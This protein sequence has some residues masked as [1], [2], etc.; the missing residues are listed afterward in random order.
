MIPPDDAGCP[1]AAAA[2]APVYIDTLLDA[3]AYDPPRIFAGGPFSGR[4][5]GDASFENWMSLGRMQE[6]AWRTR[7]EGSQGLAEREFNGAVVGL[8]QLYRDGLAVLGTVY[9]GLLLSALVRLRQVEKGEWWII[10]ALTV[11]WMND[12]G[13]YFSGRAFGKRKLY[14]RISPSKTVEGAIGGGLGSIAGALIVQYFWIPQL[15]A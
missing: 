15:P 2:G 10:L 9:P 6:L 12:T 5:G 13:A 7:I 14:E 4:W 8:Q 11:T 1:G 3:F